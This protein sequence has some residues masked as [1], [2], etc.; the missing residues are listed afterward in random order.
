MKTVKKYTV[1]S[2]IFSSELLEQWET[3]IIKV[4]RVKILLFLFSDIFLISDRFRRNPKNIIHWL[5]KKY[6]SL[7]QIIWMR[8]SSLFF[9]SLFWEKCQ[10]ETYSLST[11]NGVLNFDAFWRISLE[12][13][14]LKVQR[15]Q[16]MKSGENKVGIWGF[17]T[18]YYLHTKI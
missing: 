15:L 11:K 8:Y 4:K 7:K 2:L 18:S 13:I 12:G 16:R 17:R 3:N 1:L 6:K 5:W 10:S 14:S 9:Q